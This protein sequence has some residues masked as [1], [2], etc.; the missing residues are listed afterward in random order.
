[1]TTTQT[2]FSFKGRVAR[3]PYFLHGLLNMLAVGALSLLTIPM[4]QAGGGGVA[5]GI[6]L[7]VALFAEVIW[8]GLALQV[9]RLH[10]LGMSGLHMIWI[11]LL[12]SA[13][14][15]VGNTAPTLAIL[16]YL[17]YIGV[18]AWMLFAPGQPESNQFGPA[19]TAAT[20]TTAPAVPA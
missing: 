2:L 10:D 3:L 13:A 16:I 12:S 14:G 19:P 6:L 17:A 4:F 11:V 15:A 9:K 1:M 20:P 7:G 5:I 18:A 8:V